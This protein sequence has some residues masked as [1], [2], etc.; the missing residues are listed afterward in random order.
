MSSSTGNT[1]KT[2]GAT[3]KL[4]GE[5]FPVN[6]FTI[7]SSVNNLPYAQIKFEESNKSE[8]TSDITS[9]NFKEK[10]SSF[11]D[12]LYNKTREFSDEA[13]LTITE[14]NGTEYTFPGWLTKPTVQIGANFVGYNAQLTHKYAALANLDYSIYSFVQNFASAKQSNPGNKSVTPPLEGNIMER[15]LMLTDLLEEQDEQKNELEVE[16]IATQKEI[17]KQYKPILQELVDNSPNADFFGSDILPE[18]SISNKKINQFIHEQI[19]SNNSNLLAII[20]NSIVPNF[21]MK[22]AGDFQTGEIFQAEVTPAQGGSPNNLKVPVTNVSWSSGGGY[23]MPYNG[24]ISYMLDNKELAS[25]RQAT[26]K[27]S[28]VTIARF[29]ESNSGNGQLYVQDPPMWLKL[30]NVTSITRAKKL[31]KIIENTTDATPEGADK[32]AKKSLD[33]FKQQEADNYNFLK[34]WVKNSYYL[35]S[36]ANSTA[37]VRMPIKLNLFKPGDLYTVSAEGDDTEL[38]AGFLTKVSHTVNLGTSPPTVFTDLSFNYVLSSGVSI[39]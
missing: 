30:N 26:A 9:S 10:A 22:F 24:V 6:K 33:D 28:T 20:L 1:T 21:L 8:T 17:N 34:E 15:V 36:L 27:N 39:A 23:Q 13:S 25:A 29:P 19:T 38:F 14:D 3:F 2:I 32:E 12:I 7:T 35:V 16:S 5:S 11:Q 4:D 18:E 37:T 31:L